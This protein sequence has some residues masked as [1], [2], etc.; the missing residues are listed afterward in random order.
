L[1]ISNGDKYVNLKTAFELNMLCKVFILVI[2]N[3]TLFRLSLRIFIV[4]PAS[5]LLRPGGTHL[6]GT[7]EI[8]ERTVTL[9]K[10][11]FEGLVR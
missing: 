3:F 1:D 11:W 7:W 6:N 5:I 10:K 4:I 2:R 8:A 9:W